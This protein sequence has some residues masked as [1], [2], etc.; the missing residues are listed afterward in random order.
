M[1]WLST[2]LPLLFYLGYHKQTSLYIAAE[3]GFIDIV[4][5]LL[6]SKA[7]CNIGDMVSSIEKTICCT[8]QRFIVMF[9]DHVGWQCV[10]FNLASQ[11]IVI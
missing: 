11:I 4:K 3:N 6:H 2:F 10:Q 8:K 9:C 7:N 1:N 5:Y